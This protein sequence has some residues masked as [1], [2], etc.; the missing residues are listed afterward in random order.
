MSSAAS[1]IDFNS[2]CVARFRFLSRGAAALVSVAGLMALL[3]WIQGISSFKSVFPGF[4]TMKTNTAVALLLCGVSLW[5]WHEEELSPPSRRVAQFCAALCVL[6][7]LLTVLE[8][9]AHWNLG[10]DQLLFRDSVPVGEPYPGRM[11]LITALELFLIGSAL[12]LQQFRLRGGLEWSQVAAS[13]ATLLGFLALIGN[14]YGVSEV[15]RIG[16]FSSMAL[17]TATSCTLLG[18][19]ILFA[20]PQRGMMAILCS[21]TAGGVLLRRLVPAAILIP[22]LLGWL[23]LAGERLQYYDSEFGAALMATLVVLIIA[24]LVSWSGKSIHRQESASRRAQEEI[25]RLFTLSQ[26][27]LCVAGFDGYFKRLN[28]AWEKAL[29]YTTAELMEKPYVEFL[30][31]EDLAKTAVEADKLARG[32][33]TVAF[34]N[35]YQAKD[36]SFK[37]L[38]WNSYPLPEERLIYGSAREITARKRVEEELRGSEAKFRG[39]LEAAADGI[40]IVDQ[41]GRIVL[42]NPAAEKMFGYERAELDGQQVETLIPDRYRPEHAK[43]HAG[44]FSNPTVDMSS[45]S[46]VSAQ[47]KDSSEFPV[48]LTLS[49]LET[50]EGPLSISIIRD[51]SERKQAEEKLRVR[52]AELQAVNAELEAFTYSVS[53]DLRAP[54]RH[55]DGFS[56][57]LEE[58]CGSQLDS[59]A[60]HYLRRIRQGTHYMG[61]LVDDLLSLSRVGRQQLR[62]QVTGLNSLVEEARAELTDPATPHEANRS[63]KWRIAALPFVDC[64]PALMKQVLANLLANAIKYTRPR[65]QAIIEVGAMNQN[66]E[67]VLFVRDNGVGFS[68]KYADKLFGVFQRLHRE[69][70]FEGTGVGLATVQRILQKHGG[71]I[72]AEAELDRGACFYF[73]VGPAATET[74]AVTAPAAATVGDGAGSSSKSARAP[75]EF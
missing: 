62:R 51:I 49:I 47:R 73:T 56:R 8:Y 17:H 55:I 45:N 72:W 4:A 60:S 5:H 38:S 31:P 66:G 48:D 41:P 53:H 7:A 28:P 23:E 12:L 52:A 30:H 24:G 25:H 35:R 37:W 20:R 10:I 44:Y 26:D 68:M 9:A 1:F 75:E 14:A 13:V 21:N 54:L 36:G 32:Q 70:D 34:E 29:G 71:R 33:L 57:I 15:Y 22:P 67:T 18:L 61:E 2:R 74:G 11:S 16:A 40:V 19:G 69:E 6:V 39:L 64:D 46:D 42:A 43:F 3:G 59:S 50:S 27:L 58:E 65:Q 63:V